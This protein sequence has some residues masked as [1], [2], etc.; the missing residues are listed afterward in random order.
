M[1][2]LPSFSYPAEDGT[3]FTLSLP[4]KPWTERMLSIGGF[5]ESAAGVRAARTVRRDYL[6]DLTL[7]FDESELA[8][9][10]AFVEWAQDN[11]ATAFTFWPDASDS[12]T[13]FDAILISPMQG[14]DLIATRGETIS[15]MTAQITLRLAAGGPWDLV[16]YPE[17]A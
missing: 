8:T 1:R 11:P 13:S 15:D 9:L 14:T 6:L 2:W 5:R 3:T 7:R 4:L 17:S 12:E 10:R 16:Y